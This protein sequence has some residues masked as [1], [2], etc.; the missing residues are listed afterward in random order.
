MIPN[1]IIKNIT[2]IELGKGIPMISYVEM[3]LQD[4]DVAPGW[5]NGYNWSVYENNNGDYDVANSQ[6]KSDLGNTLSYYITHPGEFINFLYRKTVSQWCNPDFQG[7]WVTRHS[8]FYIQ[9]ELWYQI[10]NVYETVILLG[11]LAYIYFTGRHMK[12][13]RLLLNNNCCE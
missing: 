8:S 11:T 6:A 9:S 13:H 12:L 7:T 2:G 10:Y 1:T 5:Y 4:S 3:G